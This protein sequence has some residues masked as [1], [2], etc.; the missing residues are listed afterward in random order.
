M[1]VSARAGEGD[2]EALSASAVVEGAP[3]AVLVAEAG[4]V[5][6]DERLPPPPAV[7]DADGDAPLEEMPVGVDG[8]EGEAPAEGGAVV[9]GS[10]D[11][12]GGADREGEAVLGALRVQLALAGAEAEGWEAVGE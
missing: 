7:T 11:A 12:V 4:A 1:R 6:L 3:L 5:L 9:V 10:E 8:A 2:G